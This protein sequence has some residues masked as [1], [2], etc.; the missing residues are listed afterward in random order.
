[1]VNVEVTF[2]GNETIHSIFLRRHMTIAPNQD[3]GNQF[4]FTTHVKESFVLFGIYR[5]VN[6]VCEKGRT[7]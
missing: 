4:F 2:R 7:V 3:F 1:M 6:K 5:F